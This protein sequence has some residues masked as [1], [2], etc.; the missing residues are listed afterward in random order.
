MF[1]KACKCWQI[2]PR[3]QLF[4]PIIAQTSSWNQ[5]PVQG[6]EEGVVS[7]STLFWLE[8][9]KQHESLSLEMMIHDQYM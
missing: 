5:V 1:W 3:H 4:S 9:P 6:E 8:I 2:K 7:V